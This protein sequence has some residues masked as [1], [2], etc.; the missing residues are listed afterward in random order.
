MARLHC[1]NGHGIRTCPQEDLFV[2][3]S[4]LLYDCRDGHLWLALMS[5]VYTSFETKAFEKNQR[6]VLPRLSNVY[7][8]SCRL[9]HQLLLSGHEDLR[10]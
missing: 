2:K 9:S 1:F 4:T 10:L 5:V 6:S 8:C 7:T 3:L